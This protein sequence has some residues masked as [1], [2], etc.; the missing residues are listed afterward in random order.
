MKP[1]GYEAAHDA[2]KAELDRERVRL[3][4]VASTRARELLIL[5]RL[6]VTAGKSA[7]ISL[8]D[9]S[10]AELPTLDLSHLPLEVGA[11]AAGAE[12]KQTREIFASEASTILERHR[13]IVWLA[14]SRDESA[15]GPVLQAEAPEILVSDA[16]GA[17]ADNSAAATIQGGRERGLILHKLIEEILTGETAETIPD[18]LARAETLIRVLGRP[19]RGRSHPGIGAFRTRWL[20]RSCLV[21]SG[22][23]RPETRLD[24]GI[25]GLCLYPDRHA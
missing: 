2:E 1:T 11:G 23:R 24:G 22:Y 13:S 25:S 14:P 3:W 12:N 7:W 20:R 9:L 5:P 21:A 8:V 19:R 15:A 6:D 16:D 4:Y 17:P 18:L 10:L